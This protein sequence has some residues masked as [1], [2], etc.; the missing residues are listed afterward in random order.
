MEFVSNTA[1]W[2]HAVKHDST[3]MALQ[4][5]VREKLHVICADTH[6]EGMHWHGFEA[7]RCILGNHDHLMSWCPAQAR[8]LE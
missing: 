6:I 7:T 2:R 3:V 1:H 8:T 5:R 4:E